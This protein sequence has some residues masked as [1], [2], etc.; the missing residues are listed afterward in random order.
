MHVIFVEPGFPDN[1][2]EFV[3][4]LVQVGASVTGIGERVDPL[5]HVHR[6]FTLLTPPFG[7]ATPTVYR[8]WDEM[9]GP[10]GDRGN[11]LEPGATIA[12]SAASVTSSTARRSRIQSSI[13]RL[14]W[15]VARPNRS[16]ALWLSGSSAGS[17]HVS[18]K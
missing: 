6:V 12:L 10:A 9:G 16:S 8:R 18:S 1:Q 14:S 3:R 11:D 7:C 13:Q 17:G 5:P 15:S 4:A 2:R